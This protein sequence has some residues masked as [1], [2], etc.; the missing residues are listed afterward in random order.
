MDVLLKFIGD[1][2]CGYNKIKSLKG[3]PKIDGGICLDYN[4]GLKSLKWCPTIV[5]GDFS[6]SYCTSIKS[7]QFSPR[8]V[9]GDFDAVM[10]CLS[11]LD[12]CPEI[13][14]G[15][16]SVVANK[17]ESLE[18]IH[19]NIKQ[20]DSVFDCSG[21]P[22]KSHMLGLLCIKGLQKVLCDRKNIM[23]EPVQIIN[24]YLEQPMSKQR[25]FD[26]QAELID[27]GFAEYAKL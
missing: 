15:N 9:H 4:V 14:I 17:L 24:K 26:C 16:F 27:A 1:F 10:C 5:N 21:N 12:F 22:I 25:M 13:V 8:E 3:L 6:C 11:S 20:I 19:K 23:H 2:W 7:L 18:N